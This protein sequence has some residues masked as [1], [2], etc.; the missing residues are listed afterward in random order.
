M[1][2]LFVVQR[3]GREVAGGAELHCREFATRLA[4]RR[5]RVD[6]L[7]SCALSYVDW[8]N[9]YPAGTEELDGVRVHRLPVAAPRD[10]R[11]FGP[12]N[13][14]TVWSH[15]RVPLFLQHQWMRSQGPCLRGLLPWLAESAATYDVVIFFTYLY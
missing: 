7:T 2:L 3:Y 4:E 15:R 14:R 6:V 9:A 8:A 12:L 13:A 1:R 11:L 10:D 5:H